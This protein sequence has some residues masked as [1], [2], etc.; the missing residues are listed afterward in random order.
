MN[1]NMIILILFIYIDQPLTNNI[2]IYRSTQMH[3]KTQLF[4]LLLI[5]LIIKTSVSI[6]CDMGFYNSTS[7]TCTACTSAMTACASCSSGILCLDCFQGYYINSTSTRCV[8]C[9]AV[10]TGCST[11][12]TNTTCI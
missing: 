9:A 11:C 1:K 10:I 4:M 3:T 2:Y 5:A 6:T 12:R 8:G 7:T